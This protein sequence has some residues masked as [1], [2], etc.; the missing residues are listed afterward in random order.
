MQLVNWV[1]GALRILWGT[2]AWTIGLFV[3]ALQGVAMI[4]VAAQGRPATDIGHAAFEATW[5]SLVFLGLLALAQSFVL[6][7]R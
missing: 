7:F 1:W 6:R 5:F 4:G 2:P 3:F